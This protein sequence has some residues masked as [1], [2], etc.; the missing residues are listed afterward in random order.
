MQHIVVVSHWCW[1]KWKL[2]SLY[3]SH[4]CICFFSWYQQFCKLVLLFFR[5]VICTVICSYRI[6]PSAQKSL[7]PNFSH[8]YKDLFIFLVFRHFFLLCFYGFIEKMTCILDLGTRGLDIEN[9]KTTPNYLYN[10]IWPNKYLIWDSVYTLIT[11]T[12][13]IQPTYFE[14]S[15]SLLLKFLT[16]LL[17]ITCY[18]VFSHIA[19]SGWPL[20]YHFS[21]SREVLVMSVLYPKM[22]S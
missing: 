4:E 5:S 1:L 15:Q 18:S 8:F 16:S 13:Y 22:I 11:Y 7:D 9:P 17:S 10:I 12:Y 6:G 20:K 2:V 19:L 14:V 3:Y 21:L